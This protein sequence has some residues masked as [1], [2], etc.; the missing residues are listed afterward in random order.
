VQVIEVD[1]IG[2]GRNWIAVM[3]FAM[4]RALS[5]IVEPQ[6]FSTALTE[7]KAWTIVQTPHTRWQREP[8]RPGGPRS[9]GG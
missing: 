2:P 6:A 5:G 4:I 3:M 8:M 1:H 9:F 7:A